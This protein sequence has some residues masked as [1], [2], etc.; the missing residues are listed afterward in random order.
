[1]QDKRLWIKIKKTNPTPS[2]PSL[3]HPD[4]MKLRYPFTLTRSLCLAFLSTLI[5]LYSPFTQADEALTF[6]KHIRPIFRA[7]CYDCHGAEA[8]VKG[9]LDLRLVR[10]MEKGGEFGPALIKGKPD[11]SYLLERMVSGEMPPGSH[12]V[13]DEQI[14]TIRKWILEGAKTSRPEPATIGPGLGVTPEER[15][16]WAFQPIRRPTVPTVENVDRVRTPIDALLLA[17]MEK[18]D[19]SFAP[20]ADKSTLLRRA[21]LALTGLPP[22]HDE[23]AAFLADDTPEAWTKVLDRLLESPQYGERWGR[24][25]LDVAGYADS[26]GASNSDANREWAYKYRDWVIRAIAADMPFDQFITWQLA[27][28][29]LVEPPYKNM[30]TQEIDKLTATGYLRMAADGTGQSNSDET[31]NQVVIDTVKIVSTGLLGMSVGC[32]QCHDHRYDPISQEDYYR[33][34]AVFEPALNPKRWKVPGNRAVSLYTD[35]DHAKAAEIESQAQEM[36]TAR[37]AKQTEYMDLALAAEL[38]KVDEALREPLEAAYRAAGDKR[39]AEQ[40]EL[41][42]KNPNI[43]NLNPGVLYQYN[44]GHADELKKLD[45]EVAKVRATKPVHEYVR[46]LTKQAK[47]VDPTFLF[48]RGDYRQPQ[49]EVKPGGLTVAAPAD[50][51]FAIK[52]N[53]ADAPTTGRRLQYARWLT[54][55]RHPLVARVLVNRFWMHHFGTGIVDTPGEFGK[56]GSLPTQPEVLDWLA[57]EFMA[58]GWS[59]K[60]LHRV[61][62]TSTVYLQE[63]LRTPEGDQVD[64]GNQLYSHFPVKRLDA[65]AIRD[66]ILA[67]SGKLDGTSFGAPVMVGK[68]TSGQVIIAGDVQ[69]RSVYLQMKR[70]E[71]VALLK[72]FDAPAMEVNCTQRD[73]STVATQSLMMMNSDF[74]LQ[75]ASSFATRLNQEAQG[76]VDSSIIEGLNLVLPENALSNGNPWSYGYGHV[77]QQ[78]ESEIA[79]VVFTPYPFFGSN[80]WKGGEKVPDEK[81][82]FSFLNKT[83]GHTGSLDLSPIR[84]WTSPIKGKVQIKGNVHH[85]SDNGDGVRLTLYS[86]RVGQLGQWSVKHGGQDYDITV[87]VEPG[88]TLDAIVDMIDNHTSDSFSNVYKISV[89]ESES[90]QAWDSEADF[91]GPLDLSAY[92][93]KAT[94]PEQLAYGWQ[95]AY[96]R[97][98]TTQEVALSLEFI[99]QQVVLLIESGN[100]S[101]FEQAMTNY[102]QALLTSNQFLYM[103]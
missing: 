51:P 85:P 65:E 102:C 24:H 26:E 19:L 32:A 23:L 77:N 44:Q 4:V 49:H 1:M 94:I 35:E 71:P 99:Q 11:E 2:H 47:E 78:V 12:R 48:Y 98:P 14:A 93:L 82:G 5:G 8:E 60:H 42:A 100:E 3:A 73:S 54:S 15:S 75:F 58:K 103:E 55:G 56:L 28:D 30:T 88:D 13:P 7:H 90:K 61:L 97:L 92:E 9:E 79:P 72:A 67:V 21:S 29:E 43:G 38:E 16:Y 86:S 27:G 81:L 6:E 62:M 37:N 63:S 22:T 87:D 25:W 17:R 31:R 84:R 39:T 91:H 69:R 74:I 34:R 50:S 68:D 53:A 70:T 95:L 80:T 40:K 96:G 57:D 36:V 20:E 52:D 10:L 66:S 89:L 83:S 46:A 18:Q 41:L 33:L 45:A 59:L 101:P 76:K 64:G